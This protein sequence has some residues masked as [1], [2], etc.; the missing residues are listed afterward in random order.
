MHNSFW[1]ADINKD[2]TSYVKSCPVCAQLKTPRELPTRLLELLPIP[3][4]PWSHLSVDFAKDLPNSNNFTTILIITD[5]FSKACHLVQLKGLPTAM[6]TATALF[7]HVFRVYGLPEDTVTDSFSFQFMSKVWQVLCKQ[8]DINVS[9]T[10]GYHPLAN[11]QVERLNQEIGDT[12]G[13]TVVVNNSGG[14]NSF[15]GQNMPKIH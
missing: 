9:L 8:L 4:R 14:V 3:Q 2:V 7:H 15:H 10:S 12:S 11:R 1:W 5:R 6:E 13:N